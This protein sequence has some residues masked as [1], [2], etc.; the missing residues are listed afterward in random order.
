[1]VKI[2]LN[3]KFLIFKNQRGALIF[4]TI[5]LTGRNTFAKIGK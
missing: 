2:I 4:K 1:M 3:F 5:Y